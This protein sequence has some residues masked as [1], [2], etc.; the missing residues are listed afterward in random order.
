MKSYEYLEFM[1]YVKQIHTP[2]DVQV[3]FLKNNGYSVDNGRVGILNY[4][5]FRYCLYTFDTF[6]YINIIIKHDVHEC[7]ML[8]KTI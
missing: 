8:Y 3:R 1:Q 7:D 4:I 5:A 6:K 2:T